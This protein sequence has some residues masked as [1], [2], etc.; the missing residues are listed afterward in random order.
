MRA[1]LACLL[2]TSLAISLGACATGPAWMGGGRS[3]DQSRADLSSCRSDADDRM[4]PTE[5]VPP[6]RDLDSS[7]T[8]QMVAQ[9]DVTHHYDSIVSDCMQSKGYHPSN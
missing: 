8:G 2:L 7:N 1:L 9:Y 3:A 4:K 6:G 5:Y